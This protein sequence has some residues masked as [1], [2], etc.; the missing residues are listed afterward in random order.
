MRSFSNLW[1]WLVVAVVWSSASHFLIGVP[2]DLFRRAKYKGGPVEQDVKDLVRIYISRISYII[3]VSGIPIVIA[4]TFILT[5]LL[6]LGFFYD[7]EFSQAVFLLAAPLSLLGLINYRTCMKIQREEAI[8]NSAR[9]YQI[10]GRY[11]LTVQV[12]GVIDLTVTAFWGIGVN[13]GQ[14]GMGG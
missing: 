1:Y 3:E 11:R 8:Q 5:T 2:F 13:F 6:S 10:L 7:N 9:L 4:V 12:V 14:I